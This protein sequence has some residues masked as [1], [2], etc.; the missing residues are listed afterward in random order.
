MVKKNENTRTKKNY[1]YSDNFESLAND[2]AEN[3]SMALFLGAGINISGNN[4]LDWNS[5]LDYLFEQAL[6]FLSI[7]K[8][9]NGKTLYDIRNIFEVEKGTDVRKIRENM[10]YWPH[11]HR[12]VKNDFT[13]LMK[14]SIIK[15]VL[16]KN[17]ISSIQTYLYNKCNR[18]IL[19]DA[20]DRCYSRDKDEPGEYYTL[21]QLA[22]L[23][24]L[25]PN[26]RAVITYNFDNLLS[27]SIN[28]LYANRKTFFKDKQLD[29]V[30]QRQGEAPVDPDNSIKPMDISSVNLDVDLKN[31]IIP[32]YHIHGYIAPPDE[33][34]LCN[35]NEI[36]LSMDEFYD[37]ASDVFSW[38][39]ATQ[40]HY[41][42]HFTCIF[43]GLSLTDLTTQR[44][45]FNAHKQN[46]SRKMYY[47][48]A[49]HTDACKEDGHWESYM[50]L[51]NIKNCFYASYGLSPC[52]ETRG[53]KMLLKRLNEIMNEL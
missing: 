7:E 20:F 30:N 14:A 35:D 19:E 5:L 47:L 50:K 29:R 43:V 17:Y 6:T 51:Q 53:Y 32:I 26:I 40:L 52:F 21:Y 48:T 12:L 13:A 33:I 34:T 23:I 37:N 16:G 39:T 1:F 22:R 15:E 45:I 18:A 49:V 41:L 38:Q 25:Y 4:G 36:V 46:S 28:I 8:N 11:L 42:N 44:M 3:K 10:P 9:I 27:E 31:N 2:F 24:L